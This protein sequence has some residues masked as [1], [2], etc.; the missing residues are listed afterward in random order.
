MIR[1]LPGESK[2]SRDRRD[3]LIEAHVRRTQPVA[4]LLKAEESSEMALN[5]INKRERYEMESLLP[6]HAAG[7]LF[8]VKWRRR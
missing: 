2:Q 5:M 8:H 1:A 4:E 6:W 3:A 7:T